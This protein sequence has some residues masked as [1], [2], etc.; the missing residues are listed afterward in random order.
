MTKFYVSKTFW[1][2][3]IAAIAIFVMAQT[4]Y[5]ITPEETGVALAII[6]VALRAITKEPIEW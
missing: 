3:V 5:Q 6:N 1:A 2:N 4:G